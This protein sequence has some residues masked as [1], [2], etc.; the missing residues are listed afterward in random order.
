MVAF[1]F[2]P[3]NFRTLSFAPVVQVANLILGQS[4]RMN[5]FAPVRIPKKATIVKRSQHVKLF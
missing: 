2:L 4:F 1:G 5:M 3:Q